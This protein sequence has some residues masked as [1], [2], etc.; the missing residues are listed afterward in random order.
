MISSKHPQIASLK[1]PEAASASGVRLRRPKF[2]AR[3]AQV[4]L[5][6]IST[7][8]VII[9]TV[10]ARHDLSLSLSLNL[11]LCVYI[12]IY[13]YMLVRIVPCP[14]SWVLYDIPYFNVPATPLGSDHCRRLEHAAVKRPHPGLSNM[15]HLVGKKAR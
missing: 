12:Y 5:I 9:E 13:I 8:A 2:D 4:I 10:A 6:L 3:S 11:S 15:V 14:A 7:A 1:T